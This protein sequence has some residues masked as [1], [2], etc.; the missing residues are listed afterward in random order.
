M[1]TARGWCLETEDETGFSVSRYGPLAAALDG[2]GERLRSNQWRHGRGWLRR[3]GAALQV[4]VMTRAAAVKRRRLGRETVVVIV[5]YV[6]APALIGAF[7]GGG[8]WL[9]YVYW[10][11]HWP[12]TAVG[13]VADRLV[14][15][16]VLRS[17]RSRRR[18]GGGLV[19]A[20]P[21]EVVR[22]QWSSVTALSGLELVVA[23]LPGS[24]EALSIPD[25]R[26]QLGVDPSIKVALVFGAIYDEKDPTTVF[27]AFSQLDDWQLVVAGT[28]ADDVPPTT[29]VLRRYPGF[30]DE[31]TRALLY[32]AADLVI[33]SFYPGFFRN[34]GTLRDAITW[35]V[36]VVCSDGSLPSEIVTEYELGTV[37]QS[38]NPASL[39]RAVRAAPSKIDPAQ[40]A[41]A[42]AERSN[43]VSAQHALAALGFASRAVSSAH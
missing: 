6:D 25:A 5:S 10:E 15:S 17:E 7:A 27:E 31:R 40:L 36:P 35:A 18:R 19:V 24:G 23:A 34:S 21:S 26:T 32:S 43:R 20:A 11:P 37:F 28:L 38:G 30:V 12:T 2:S 42:R 39:V 13:V 22:E 4:I 8:S 3:M 41:R 9:V 29:R 1:L 16:L 14:R 33:I